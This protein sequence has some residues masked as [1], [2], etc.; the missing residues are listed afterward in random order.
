MLAIF[1]VSLVFGLVL[2]VAN[3][4]FQ[5]DAGN[6][7]LLLMG[8]SAFMIVGALVVAHRPGNAIG[9]LFS[10]SALL[11]FTGQLADQYAIYAYATRPEPLPGVTLAAWYGSW[12]W[13][14]VLALTLVFTPLLFPTG[15]LLS[16]RWRPV[17]WLAGVTT[18]GLTALTSLRTELDIDPGQ[19]IAN[20]IGVVAVGNPEKGPVSSALSILLTS[21]AAVAF[22]SL[23]LRLRRSRGEERQQLKWFTYAATLVPLALAGDILPAPVGDLIYAIPIVFLPVAAG[24]A[25]LRYRLYDIDRLIN[26]TLVYGLLTAVLAA[27]YA[28]VVLVLVQVS[29]GIAT[30]PPSWA[31]AGATLA[32]AALF[33]PV[34]RR[35]QAAVD[36]RFNR[37]KYNTTKTIEAFSTRLRDQ[38]DLNSLSTEM[39]AVV[40]QTMEP[41][42]VSLWL[43]PSPYGSSGPAH[44]EARPTTWAY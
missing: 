29:G 3:G 34:R 11:A 23:V 15:R 10:A 16:P 12:P 43:R 32:A 24:L 36:R 1:A 38:I 9:W 27:V 19:V 5:Q 13:W 6:Q 7:V 37:H 22:G 33:Q 18:A 17:A 35:I 28:G 8:F 31:V 14:L 26:R 39:L 4:T 42:Q 20:P 25:I 30:K 2:A 41:T 40:D 44:G 21:L